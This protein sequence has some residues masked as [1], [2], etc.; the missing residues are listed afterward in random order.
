MAARYH[1]NGLRVI[2][3]ELIDEVVATIVDRFHPNRI[4][5]FGSHA[6]GEAGPDSDLDLM[7]EMDTPLRLIDRA[8]AVGSLFLDR[9]WPLDVVVY[10]PEEV[11]HGRRTFGNLLTMIEADARTL[12]EEAAG[13]RS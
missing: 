9:D 7:L 5:L 10:T 3:Q 2:D 13:V 6:R 8:V 4:T 12:Y 1:P 11:E